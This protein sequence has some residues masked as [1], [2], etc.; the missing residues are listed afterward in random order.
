MIKKKEILDLIIPK[1]KEDGYFPVKV[2]VKPGNRIEVLIDG[3][4]G[5]PID[6]CVEISRLIENALDRE[7]E[8][9]ELQVSS[10]GIGQPFKVRE[11]FLKN[12][13]RPVEV[14]LPDGRIWKGVLEKVDNEGFNIK[15]EKKVKPEGKKKKELQV[16]NH[17]FRF[18]EI[19]KVKELIYL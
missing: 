17:W 13:D 14:L 9:F 10:P 16:F 11:Q 7:V 6:Y 5:V 18:D 8:D 1:L 19:Q 12:I 2:N 15:E 3:E 4:N